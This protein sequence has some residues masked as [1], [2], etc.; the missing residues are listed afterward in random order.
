[1]I[2]LC[3]T[4]K[5]VFI[6]LL[7]L[8]AVELPAQGFRGQYSPAMKNTFFGVNIGSIH[9]PFSTRQLQPGNT[10]GSVK[11]PHTAVRLVLG[12]PGFKKNLSAQNT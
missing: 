9:Y 2:Q 10:V 5:N 8:A 11:V 4:R 1:M 6:I 12:G 7:L 3:S